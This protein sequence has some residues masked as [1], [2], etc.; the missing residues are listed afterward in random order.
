M[1]LRSTRVVAGLAFLVLGAGAEAQAPP[2]E[3]EVAPAAPEPA[4][5]A[6]EPAP[7]P[8]VLGRSR[9]PAVPTPPERE[10]PRAHVSIVSPQQSRVHKRSRGTRTQDGDGVDSGAALDETT[11]P[12]VERLE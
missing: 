11:G 3:A 6:S 7:A 12:S 1:W 8:N 10:A 4:P 5:P 2:P 9:A